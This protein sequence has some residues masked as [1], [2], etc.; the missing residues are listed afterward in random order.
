MIKEK[1]KKELKLK[2]QSQ[3]ANEAAIK[4]VEDLKLRN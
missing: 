4:A 2:I 3:I 1:C